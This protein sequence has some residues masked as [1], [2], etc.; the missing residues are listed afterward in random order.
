MEFVQ[1]GL[2]I[3]MKRYYSMRNQKNRTYSRQEGKT[4][5]S[6]FIGMMLSLVVSVGLLRGT[7][8]CSPPQGDKQQRDKQQAVGVVYHDSNSNGVRDKAEKGLSGVRVS[9]G[10]Q[11]VKTDQE[12]RYT[13]P[14]DDET[15][16]F[17]IKPKGWMTPVSE[18]KLPRFFY[19]HMPKGSPELTEDSPKP[20][21]GG[22][23]PT[24]PLPESVDFPLHP[25]HEPDRF[26]V[27]IL[28]DTQTESQREVDYLAHDVVEE[29]VGV[30]AA[31]GLTLGDI[32]DDNLSL[33][34]SVAKAL[35]VIGLP[36]Y[37][38]L[39]NHDLNSVS[40]FGSF[41]FQRVFGPPYY[42]FDYGDVH[43]IVLDFAQSPEEVEFLT[44]DLALVPKDHLV[45]LTMHVPFVYMPKWY[46]PRLQVISDVLK[47]R[48][49]TFSISG[50][51]HLMVNYFLTEKDGWKGE[52][53]HHH[54]VNV[55][56]GDCWAGSLDQVGIPQGLQADGT[57][58]GYS[59]VTF[60]G[61]SYSVEFKAARRPADYQM[62][63]YAP[64]EVKISDTT[65][66]KVFAN[67]FAG[68]E[69]SKVEMRL[70]ESEP[71][72]AMAKL[73]EAF[74]GAPGPADDYCVQHK[75]P[76][77]NRSVLHLWE[78]NLPE[79]S[80]EGTYLIHVR[81]TDMYGHTYTAHRVI[82]VR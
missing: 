58:H 82:R 71:W 62:N 19:I 26:R 12:G 40:P 23:Q 8:I 27:L 2:V 17:V 41:S 7:G 15:I 69:K 73:Q 64:E 67:I 57:P 39:G 30:D 47:E 60:D 52:R 46:R 79:I 80:E 25:Q 29:L 33:F 28:A 4:R 35:G 32:V 18:D 78:A 76:R 75:M 1:H 72:M 24:G 38:V 21:F 13:I 37:N 81:T 14:V 6:V 77:V 51:W 11:I 63:I 22:V 36:W 3:Y 10:R 42:S 45:V 44:N 68:S 43:F 65:K 61:N 49:H 5:K 31:F 34:E 50:H 20:K 16:I 66:T 9:N 48:P 74:E 59:I 55:S 56:A 70:G 53:S 54:M